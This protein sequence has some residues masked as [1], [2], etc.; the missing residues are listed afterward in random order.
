MK[1]FFSSLTN[2]IKEKDKIVLMTH[3]N[4][5]L[6]GFSSSL[7]LYRIIS[8]MHKDCY[9]YLSDTQ[10]NDGIKKTI[11]KLKN[12]NYEYNTLYKNELKDFSFKNTLLII[13]DVYKYHL[14]ENSELIELSN[15]TVVIDHHIQDVDYVKSTSLAYINSNM[16]S[17]AEIIV[18]YC[19]YINYKP[20]PLLATILLCAIEIDTNYFNF[21]TTADTYMS[22]AYL[23]NCGASTIVKQ[24]LLRESKDKYMQRQFYIEQS[25][26]IT[27]DI[28]I[29][30]IEDKIVSSSELAIV[31]DNLLSFEGI[32]ASFCIGRL[33]ENTIGISAR[34]IGNIDVQEIMCKFG[35]GGHA[36]D[37]ATKIKDKD[38][39]E[40]VKELIDLLKGGIK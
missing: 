22:A 36:T 11:E 13:V 40:C 2:K 5:D 9:L 30:E 10:N 27:D 34:S 14:V 3:K 26:Q 33:E 20:D 29:C 31:A 4:M 12:K 35:G 15:D 39:N 18:E 17:V 19:K 37:A 24:D 7:C 8:N 6:D 28:I 23:T 16:S 32:E 21:K 25:Y 1:E 38:I